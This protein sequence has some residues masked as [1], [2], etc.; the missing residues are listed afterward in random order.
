MLPPD[1][2]QGSPRQAGLAG[3]CPSIAANDMVYRSRAQNLARGASKILESFATQYLSHVLAMQKS[4]PP[5]QHVP[6]QDDLILVDRVLAGDRRAFEPLVR[7]HERRVFR[8]TLAV[9][10]N[11]EDAE[12]ALQDTFVKTFRNLGQFRRESKFTTWLTRIAINEALRKVQ[13]RRDFVSLDDSRG[14]DEWPMPRRTESWR[15]DPE[16]L[17]GKHELRRIVEVAIQG[18]PVIYREAFVLRDI[19]E[20]TAEEAAEAIG[21]TVG[22]LK[23]RILRARLL[24]REALAAS[25]QVP[26]NV[27]KRI[28]HAAEGLGISVAIRLMRAVRKEV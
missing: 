26:P 7:R 3:A 8:V 21:I 23:S 25:L 11:I 5:N 18:L 4:Q 13:G 28:L 6:D 17:Y 19:E 2:L 20:M 10:G 1:D 14:E 15:T 22:A 16:S 24:V 9:L 12:E 27:S